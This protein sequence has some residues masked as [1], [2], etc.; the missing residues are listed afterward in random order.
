MTIAEKTNV[1]PKACDPRSEC[2]IAGVK[3]FAEALP[4]TGKEVII[5]RRDAETGKYDMLTACCEDV[6]PPIS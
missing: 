6:L 1:A 3:R 4:S 2:S 5:F